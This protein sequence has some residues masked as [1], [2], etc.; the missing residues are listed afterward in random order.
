MQ[1][2]IEDEAFSNNKQ[3]YSLDLRGNCISY[4]GKNAFANL[5][6]LKTLYLNSNGLTNIDKEFVGH[7]DI[8]K[9]QNQE[10]YY[11]HRIL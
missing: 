4:I 1:S 8:L 10:E 7:F 5:K 9:W 2:V 11:I 3:L 6:N